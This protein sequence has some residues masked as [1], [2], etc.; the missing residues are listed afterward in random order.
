MT[1]MTSVTFRGLSPK[2]II[3]LCAACGIAGI[4]WGGDVHVPTTQ[5]AGAAAVAGE[6]HAAGL[7][8]LSYGSYYKLNTGAV[9][10]PVLRAAQALGAPRVRIWAGERG[11]QEADRAY[12]DAAAA[13]LRAIC[14]Q[15]AQ[16][17]IAVVLEYHRNTLTDIA[18][19]A[20]DLLDAADCANL[21]T[22]WQPNP[23]LTLPQQ[24]REIR[25]LGQRIDA[26]HV[27]QWLEG[28]ARQDLAA[29]EE[30]WRA[31]IEQLGTE[32]DYILEFVRDDSP[33]QFSRD[34]A[35]LARWLS[36]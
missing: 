13:E 24:L 30:V 36:R 8:V 9:F 3:S 31:Y 1:G 33:E 12:R 21:R 22:Y 14:A 23:D 10:A 17:G 19:S 6:T 27:F 16:A 11:S 20:R 15:A 25:L 2:Q 18:D 7:A 29:G 35:T 26:V 5:E 28:N 34:A 4:E 32:R